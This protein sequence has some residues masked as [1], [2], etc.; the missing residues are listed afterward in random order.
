MIN[1]SGTPDH[2][3]SGFGKAL[4]DPS[5]QQIMELC[6][7]RWINVR[8]LVDLTGLAQ[9]TVSHHLAV[10]CEA[11]LVHQRQDGKKMFYTLNQQAIY[12]CCQASATLFAPEAASQV[13]NHVSEE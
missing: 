8:E 12:R 9:S 1:H 6:C 3:L 2:N 7:C 11:G 13:E 10:L 4:S 5:R